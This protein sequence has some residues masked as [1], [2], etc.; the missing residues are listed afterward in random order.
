MFNFSCQQVDIV[1]TKDGIRTL[2]DIIIVNPTWTYLLPQFY[3]T[4]GFVTFDAVQAKEKS[5]HNLDPNDQFFHLVIEMFGC[6]HKQANVF[7]LHDCANDIWNFKRPDCISFFL[8]YFSLSK[9]FNYIAKE[10]SSI[11]S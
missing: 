6:L 3:I 2:V 1:F 8:G 7:F 4:Q 10:T 5:Y 11:L 9:N